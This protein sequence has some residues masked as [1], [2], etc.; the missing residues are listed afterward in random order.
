M[1]PAMPW[2]SSPPDFHGFAQVYLGGTWHNVD[3]T[4]ERLRPALV[5]IAVGRDAA[6]VPMLT[7]WGASTF[8]EQSVRSR[9]SQADRPGSRD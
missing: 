3:A 5:P 1:S 2:A 9:K 6:D 4:F 8:I 7:F